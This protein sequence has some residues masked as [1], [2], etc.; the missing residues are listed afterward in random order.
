[1]VAVG[2]QVLPAI[3]TDAQVR[4]ECVEVAKIACGIDMPQQIATCE[5]MFG[6]GWTALEE[7][8]V[9]FERKPKKCVN[10][11]LP[12]ARSPFAS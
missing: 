1:M 11:T 10:V 2:D 6:V 3:C 9:I 12:L 8:C 5:R 7:S 4:R